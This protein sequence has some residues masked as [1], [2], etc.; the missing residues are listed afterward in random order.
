MAG[1]VSHRATTTVKV[2]QRSDLEPRSYSAL[3]QDSL[4]SQGYIDQELLK[5][6]EV[7]EWVQDLTGDLIRVARQFPA[8]T[9]LE[10]RDDVLM[11][12]QH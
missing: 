12:R 7:K 2:A 8:G 6:P 11:V 5:D 1:A 9:V 3:I 10:R 4:E